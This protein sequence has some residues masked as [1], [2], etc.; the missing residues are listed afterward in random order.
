MAKFCSNCGAQMNDEDKVCGQCGTPVTGANVNPAPAAAP[1]ADEEKKKN[2]NKI[3]AL[4]AIA[5]V[6]IVA[7]VVV[8]N[9]ASN[10]TG[11]KG[12]LNKM[13]K[14][15]KDDDTDVLVDL[16]SSI[17][18]EVNEA[19]YGDDYEDYYED[20]VDGVLDKYEDKVEN[21]KKISY[22]ITD[23]TELSKRQMEDLE[24]AM[25]D[26][27]DMDF[28]DIKK[29]VKV[30]LKITVKGSKKSGSY[31]VDDLIMVK[32]DGGWKIHYGSLSY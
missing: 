15:L 12:T 7:I 1:V 11:Y 6:A 29:V 32:E 21:I 23:E 31:N 14:A 25:I 27:Y 4:I 24:E 16:A 30:D 17:S 5:I 10:F 13:V 19:W 18:N 8:A 22:E 9:I 2:N 26:N 3:I 20:A 28:S